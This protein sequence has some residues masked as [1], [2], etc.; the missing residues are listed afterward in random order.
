MHTNFARF[1]SAL[2]EHVFQPLADWITDRTGLR[3]SRVAGACLDMASIAWIMSQAGAVTQRS[4]ST[5]LPHMLLLL[6]GLV[7]L[8]SLRTMFRRVGAKSGANPLRI[9]M[10]PHR[11][12]VLALLAARLMAP[13][14]FASLA[15]LA[16]LGFAACA[17]YLGACA[18]RPPVQRRKSWLATSEAS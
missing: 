7:A 12:I 15:D 4:T 16:M 8:S 2:I 1:D 3:Q 18:T 17:L 10:L 5:A 11:G 6:L 14:G 9:A 13:A